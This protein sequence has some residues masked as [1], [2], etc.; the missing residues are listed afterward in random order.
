MWNDL[1][2][3]EHIQSI[4]VICWYYLTA[5]SDFKS[6]DSLLLIFLVPGT[7]AGK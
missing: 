7:K 1:D 2:M 5:V 6:R 3:S 4:G